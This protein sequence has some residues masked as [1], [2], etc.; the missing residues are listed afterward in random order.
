[1]KGVCQLR[2]KRFKEQDL[3]AITTGSKWTRR[4]W[5]QQAAMAAVLLPQDFPGGWGGRGRGR[6]RPRRT[7]DPSQI[8]SYKYR[9]L[10]V[11]R[12][13]SLQ[14][15]TTPHE[16]TPSWAALNCIATRSLL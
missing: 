5:L 2:S 11:G 6:F 8:P 15:N 3:L 10:P 13:P 1:M 16:I 4:E 14:K 9:I 7:V 12:F